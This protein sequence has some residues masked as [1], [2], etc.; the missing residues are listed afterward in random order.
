[1]DEKET[2]AVR[3]LEEGRKR[4]EAERGRSELADRTFGEGLVVSCLASWLSALC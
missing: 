4:F 1:M 2:S 3:A